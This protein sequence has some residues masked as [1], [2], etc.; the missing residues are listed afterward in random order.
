M[1]F[2]NPTGAGDYFAMPTVGVAEEGWV[3]CRKRMFRVSN[4]YSS[5]ML[6]L[7][8]PGAS[9]LV[10]LESGRLSISAA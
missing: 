8:Y 9:L 7:G 4:P 2:A 5:S 3:A 1:A 6:S 10:S